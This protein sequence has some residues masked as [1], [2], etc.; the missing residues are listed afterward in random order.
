M[1]LKKIFILDNK[2]IKGIEREKEKIERLLKTCGKDVQKTPENVDLIIAMGGDGTF[3]KGVHLI[4]NHRT[5]IYGI[6]YGN[7]GFL[8]D[9]ARDINTKLKNIVNGNFRTCRRMLLDVAIRKNGR[10]IRDFCLNE[11]V[12]FR[13]NIRIINVSAS[14]RNETIFDGMRADGLII[15]TPTGSTAHSLSAFGPVISPAM[16]CLLV[17]PMSPHSISW[18]PVVLP[19]DERI[20]VRISPAASLAVDGQREF[21]LNEGDRVTVRKSGKAIRI[22]MEEDS[23]FR[24]LK[25]KFNW[26]M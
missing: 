8:A 25:S 15:S 26:G 17:I 2:K 20:E 19:P 23:F 13:K 22:I 6:K 14:D 10:T 24:K 4:T 12:F 18:R 9:S 16:E 7:V 21:E 1:M 11:V 5:L 3:L